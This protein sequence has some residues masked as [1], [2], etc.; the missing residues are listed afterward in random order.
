MAFW[1]IT[2]SQYGWLVYSFTN[3]LKNRGQKLY[4]IHY[5]YW[6]WVRKISAIFEPIKIIYLI[7]C[8]PDVVLTRSDD[9]LKWILYLS[10]KMRFKLVYM[11]AHDHDTQINYDK[12]LNKFQSLLMDIKYI[13]AQN[14]LQRNNYHRHFNN[15]MIPIIPN[16]WI[17]KLF[18]NEIGETTYDFIWVANF[19]SM[20]RPE[21]YIELATNLPE[22]KFAM[23]GAP[24]DIALF[25]NCKVKAKSITNLNFLGYKSFIETTKLIYSSKIL[26]NTSEAE[27][28]PNTFL[29]AWSNNI[30]TI[31]TVDPRS[32]IENY[33]L[34]F[35][36]KSLKELI[37]KSRI[38]ITDQRLLESKRSKINS[39][40]SKMHDPEI[41]YAI[42]SDFINDKD[43]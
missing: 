25:E 39:Y 10:K 34:G 36:V 26:I 30:P 37:E 28:F 42:L 21:W 17:T 19:K 31:A 38:L 33:D 43:K 6:P 32:V 9:R 24:Q 4:G 14:E 16:I 3:K 27:G 29:Q 18:E 23:V 1:A 12:G 15:T 13:I 2:F 20:K 11:L 35:F 8:N 7:L 41:N 40:F 5:L 22:F